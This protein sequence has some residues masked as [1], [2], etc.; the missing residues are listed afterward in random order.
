[1]AEREKDPIYLVNCV[2]SFEKSRSPL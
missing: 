2:F 1:M